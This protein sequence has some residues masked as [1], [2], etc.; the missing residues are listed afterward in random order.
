ML[1]SFALPPSTW[2]DEY[3][4]LLLENVGRLRPTADAEL[5]AAIEETER[6][7]EMYRRFGHSYGYVFYLMRRMD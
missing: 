6:E 3:Y 2:W 5:M 1:D 7:I 4:T